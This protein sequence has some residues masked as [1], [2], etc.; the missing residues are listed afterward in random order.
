ML[1]NKE[2]N[3][4]KTLSPLKSEMAQATLKEE[5]Q[6]MEYSKFYCFL[7][8]GSAWS[9]GFSSAHQGPMTPDFEGFSIPDFIHYILCSYLN[10]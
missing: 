4:C 5:K 3:T 6:G 9:F 2:V 1:L 8:F 7:A 10:S